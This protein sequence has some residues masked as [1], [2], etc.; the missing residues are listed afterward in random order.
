[1]ARNAID[2]YGANMFALEYIEGA[3]IDYLLALHVTPRQMDL[4]I[5][6]YRANAFVFLTY[7]RVNRRSLYYYALF[8]PFFS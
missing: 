4:A 5:Q 8:F 1:M 3:Y 6:L 2:T 7:C